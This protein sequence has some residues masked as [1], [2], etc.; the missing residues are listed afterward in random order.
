LRDHRAEAREEQRADVEFSG[1]E[2]GDDLLGDHL[3]LL[4]AD[5]LDTAQLDGLDDLLAINPAQ[6][7]LALAADAEDLDVLALALQRIRLLAREP[8]NRRIERTAQAALGG[9]DHQ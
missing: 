3:G 2:Q 1:V 5:L 6:L 9:T 7:V 8:H 4:E